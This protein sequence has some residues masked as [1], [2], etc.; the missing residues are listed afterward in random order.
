MTENKGPKL[1]VKLT[2]SVTVSAREYVDQTAVLVG[3]ADAVELVM[4]LAKVSQ[5]Q[6]EHLVASGTWEGYMHQMRIE[7]FRHF[8]EGEQ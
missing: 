4:V 8:Q 1:P 6:A 2:G 3:G 5:E 7:S